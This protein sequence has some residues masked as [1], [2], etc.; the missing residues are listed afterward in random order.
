M[1]DFSLDRQELTGSLISME[2]GPGGRIQQ[3]WASD[4]NA[5]DENEEF[6]FVAPPMNMG[7]ELTDDYFP[8]TVLVG[9]RNHPEDPWIV[10]RNSRAEPLDDDDHG[11]TIGFRYEFA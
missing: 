10:S 1:D 6:Q 11:Q 5:P 2:F 3:L 8:G 4:P 9:A 7:E